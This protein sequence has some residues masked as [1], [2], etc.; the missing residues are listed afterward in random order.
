MQRPCPAL[1]LLTIAFCASAKAATP[2]ERTAG[3]LRIT[4]ER[5]D[6]GIRLGALTDTATGQPL[7]ARQS[8][9]LF[10]LTMRRSGSDE[11]AVL[12]ADQGWGQVDIQAPTADQ[13]ELRWA[14]PKDGRLAGLAVTMA[15]RLDSSA[16]AICWTLRVENPNRQWSVWRVAFPQIALAD[17]G[18]DAE[19]LFP[20]GPGEVQRG[21]WQKPFHYKDS[22]PYPG[23]WT[24]MQFMAAYDRT[25]NTGLYFGIHDPLGS[26]KDITVDSQPA[27]HAVQFLVDHPAEQ[28]GIAGNRFASS[29]QVVWQLLRGDWFDAAMV[30]RRW[31]RAEAQWYP[32]LG[33]N[34]R[35]DT[36]LWMRELPAWA[37]GGGDPWTPEGKPSQ[38]V[39]DFEEFQ[40]FLGVP[41]GVHW[42]SW[43]AIP[44]DNDY[45]HYFPTKKG[46][47]EAVRTLQQESVY[48]MPYINGRLWDMRDKGTED[49]EFTRVALPAATKNQKGQ[50]NTEIY[51]S[52]ESDGSPVRLAVMCPAATLWQ[53]RLKEIVLGLFQQCGVKGVYIDQIAAAGP[54]LC[55]DKNH[56]HPLGGGH[57]WTESY[58]RLLG[59]IRQ[60]MPKD[61]IL[62]TE[63]NAEP[64]IRWF[65]G[66]L[67]WHWQH[68]GQVPA[69]PAVYGGSLQM[70]GRAYRGGPSKDLALRMKAG[71]QLVFGE[72][73]G[74]LNPG[75]IH[76]KDNAAFLRQIVQLRWALRR[77]F[78][79]GEM[80]RPPKLAGT[81]PRVT[82]DWQW[83]GQWPVSTDAVLTGAWRL[84]AE[85]KLVL[86]LVNVSDQP[87]TAKLQLDASQ[88]GLAASQLQLTKLTAGGAAEK[89]TTPAKIDQEPTFPPR[90]AW[91]WELALP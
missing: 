64:F 16:S 46:F 56:G 90:A 2:V 9:P 37:V 70:F 36:P 30:Y 75:I 57:W 60:A 31:V 12:A 84:P 32:R 21:L 86:L 39:K 45:P 28:M 87:V 89:S 24:T 4:L 38:S 62:T 77:Y 78:Y 26:V 41:V 27:D 13:L 8:L 79:A 67:T 42:Y 76:E 35:E 3:D 47:A 69:F 80:A 14:M 25:R 83:S 29:G 17:F 74:W 40:K 68:D 6:S 44:F 22:Y 49:F 58:W 43:H 59:A 82:A 54:V 7:S 50:P 65:D 33:P 73:I 20:R 19:V 63:C 81:M 18:P 61:R 5:A 1:L 66:Y 51:G 53:V 55:F 71:Q 34:G 15:A 72:Q 10:G 23:A 52:K 88:Y 85:H 11:Q 48:V 91:A